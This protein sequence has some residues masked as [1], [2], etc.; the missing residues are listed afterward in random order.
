MKREKKPFHC[1]NACDVSMCSAVVYAILLST[2]HMPRFGHYHCITNAVYHYPSLTPAENTCQE[3][4]DGIPFCI[5]SEG[6]KTE[7]QCTHGLLMRSEAV[8]HA[9]LSH[10]SHIQFSPTTHKISVILILMSSM[11]SISSVSTLSVHLTLWQRN[12][13]S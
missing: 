1:I 13:Y 4:T 5:T 8:T 6:A 9:T 12:L 11:Y 3:S 7:K 2:M 10:S